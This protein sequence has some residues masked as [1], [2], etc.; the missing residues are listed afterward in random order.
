MNPG[1]IYNFVSS[2]KH[3]SYPAALTQTG[4][5]VCDENAG[6]LVSFLTYLWVT[7]L[8]IFH[9]LLSVVLTS[10]GAVWIYN[11][12]WVDSDHNKLAHSP[13]LMLAAMP[14]LAV[15]CFGEVAQHIFDNWLDL[16][17]IPTTYLAIFYGG[18]ALG[19]SLLA[20][21]VWDGP[22]GCWTQLLPLASLMSFA[23][24]LHNGIHC[25]SKAR[26]LG[27]LGND[28]DL[29]EADLVWGNCIQ[30]LPFIPSFATLGV[31]T[32][33]IFLKSKAPWAVRSR[34]LCHAMV[35]LVV[36]VGCSL[37]V[38]K[39]GHQFF[40]L[41]TA[42]GFLALFVTELLYIKNIPEVNK[43]GHGTVTET[44]SLIV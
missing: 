17:M 14:V 38:P 40:H 18:L 31:S 34:S 23:T 42:G 7:L 6:F 8:V 37:L 10:V 43:K 21:G 30:F 11:A 15:A 27:V 25:N 32:V 22:P 16:G 36:G 12:Q 5:I 35:A 9:V 1:T 33:F 13:G 4:R 41:P 20:L 29:S 2:S 3:H 39:T 19:Q 28:D 26:A 44:S 24:I